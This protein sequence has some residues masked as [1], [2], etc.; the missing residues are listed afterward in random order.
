MSSDAVDVQ[1]AELEET[2]LAKKMLEEVIEGYKTTFEEQTEII[3]GKDFEIAKLNKVQSLRSNC[4]VLSIFR[5]I[6]LKFPTK[7]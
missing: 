7:K 4:Y 1:L 2:I 6:R 5:K 3:E